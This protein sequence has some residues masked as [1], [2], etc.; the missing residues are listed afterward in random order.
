[1]KTFFISAGDPSGDIHAA[2]L[3]KAIK[4]IEPDSRFIG[5]GG[6][7]CEAQGLVSI[8]PIEQISV[9]GFWEVAKRYRMFRRLLD[10]C[11]DILLSENV[12]AFIPV[13]YPGF[14]LPLAKYAKGNNIPVLYY[15][16]PQLWAWGKHRAQK[17][18]S[19]VDKLLVVFPFETDFFAKYDIDVE[20]VG[21]PLLDSEDF[22]GK[23]NTL[24]DR[25]KV[26]AL[27]PGSRVQEIHRH[28]PLYSKI[29]DLIEK[30]L[31]DYEIVMASAKNLN[32]DLYKSFLHNDK[33]RKIE[34]DAG[35]LMKYAKCGLV[36]TGTTNL[37]ACLSGLPFTMVYKTSA[38]TY[39][40][41][42]K[43]INL[44]YLSLAN[45]LTNREIVKEFIQHEAKPEQI[46]EELIKLA[47]NEIYS[48]NMANEFIS[49]RKMLGEIG[50]ST[51]AA[52]I[53]LHNS[54]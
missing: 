14:N 42:K 37:E 47:K 35:K 24:S 13:D 19:R 17:L 20:F 23:P 54:R 40:M 11:R 30:A 38:L 15:I 5:I 36:K 52:K 41:G 28:L 4:E 39:F 33:K 48:Q 22:I 46:A 12:S 18:S 8:V 32:P 16:A 53:I 6:K 43:L 3:I 25:E 1:M 50:A 2:K 26:I 49:I 7:E 10:K 31:P 51:K 44:D 27:F 21:H 9:V 45:I 29:A 34:P